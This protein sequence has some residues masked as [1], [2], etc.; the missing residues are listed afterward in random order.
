MA[1]VAK[2][3]RRSS[4]ALEAALLGIH[5][6]AVFRACRWP[7][8]ILSFGFVKKS[9]S[10]TRIDR[11]ISSPGTHAGFLLLG[12]TVHLPRIAKAAQLYP[13]AILGGLCQWYRTVLAFKR[14][15]SCCSGHVHPIHAGS[16]DIVSS[17]VAKKN[18][19]SSQRVSL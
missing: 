16:E 10:R 9:D 11:L 5:T 3:N 18:V 14:H 17:S 1:I 15:F 13:I 4:W 12:A 8:S 2:H 19:L 6:I 7:L